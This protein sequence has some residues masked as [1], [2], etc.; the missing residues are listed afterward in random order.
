MF[1]VLA[2]C[3]PYQRQPVSVAANAQSLE[4]RS[5]DAPVVREL[6]EH[7]HQ[8]W[9]PAAWTPELLALAAVALHP[10]LDVARAEWETARAALRTAAERPNPAAAIGVEHKSGSDSVSPWVTTLSFDVPVETA[11]KR[12]VRIAAA[13]ALAT[14][15]AADVDQAI[16]NVR[17][18]AE[19]AV[20]DL[21]ASR[22]LAT[23][24][25][26]EVQLRAEIVSILER[27]LELGEAAQPDVSRVRADDRTARLL[28]LA[29][30][31]R[32]S[33][34]EAALASAIG[35]PRAALP[36]LDLTPTANR[37]PP[38]ANRP[39]PPLRAAALTARPDVLAAVARYEAAEE[40]LR[41]EV[42]KQYPDLRIG[43]GLGFDQGSFTWLLS[44]SAEL[45]I[46]NQHRGPIAE[47]AARRSAAAAR[48]LALQSKVLGD[49]ESALAGERSARARLEESERALAAKR[50][51]AAAARRQFDAGEI[52]RLAL[53]TQ[54]IEVALAAI[55]RWSAWFDLRRA[56]IA[57][58][59]AVEQ[60]MG[61]IE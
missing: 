45:P 4:T 34:A 24:R 15:A 40:A 5:L 28:L 37:Q 58:E 38:T 39:D 41:L 48:L 17:T 22:E 19:R 13:N 21:A 55:D 54:E 9:P 30:E 46:F 12:G 44:A 8:T 6:V 23:A 60:P 27:R 31:G 11:G 52:D 53:R 47:A 16:W 43:P 42:R 56:L 57:V 10:D 18:R 49:L 50:A 59:S 20:V 36:P 32:T 26:N 29:E 2:G 35:I 3:V 33:E 25:R 61:D 51:A 7:A 1:V 14:A